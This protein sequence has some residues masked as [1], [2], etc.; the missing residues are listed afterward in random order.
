M[1]EGSKI[2]IEIDYDVEITSYLEYVRIELH[3]KKRSYY[4]T[5]QK[6]GFKELPT[7][8]KCFRTEYLAGEYSSGNM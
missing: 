1:S 8:N 2:V 3:R 4:S 6:E 5:W 7:A